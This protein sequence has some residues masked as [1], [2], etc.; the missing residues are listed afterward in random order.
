MALISFQNISFHYDSPY[1][2]IFDS[3]SFTLDASWKTG[4]VGRNGRGKTTLL[5]LLTGGLE[6][7]KGKITALPESVYFPFSVNNPEL[8]ALEAARNAVEDFS[9]WEEEMARLLSISDEK[10]LERYG[11]LEKRYNDAGGYTVR[12][13]LLAD[14][15]ALGLSPETAEKPFRVLS[16]GEKTKCLIAALFRKNN[17][18]PLLDEPTNHLDMEGREI[19]GE[20]LQKQKGFLVISHDRHFLDLCTDHILGLEKNSI[21]VTKGNFS[22]W[23]EN[24]DRKENFER[25]QSDQI[26]RELKHLEKAARERRMHS[27]KAESGKLKKAESEGG[28]D[29]GAIGAVS[30]R[31]MKRAKV[32]E[33]RID[34]GIG[35]KKELLR[36]AVKNRKLKMDTVSEGPDILLRGD[37]ISIGFDGRV[38][39]QN[40]NFQV[41]KGDRIAVIGPNGCGKTS[42]I[43]A[44][45]GEI[46]LLSGTLFRPAHIRVDRV[47]QYPRYTNGLLE[48]LVAAEEADKIRNILAAFGFSGDVLRKRAEDLSQGEQKKFEIALSLVKPANLYIW[49]EPL[50]AVDLAGRE[51]IERLI[52]ETQ[53]AI[54]F[55]EHDRRFIENIATDIVV[56]EA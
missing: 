22:V 44:V 10:S 13:K 6:P 56:L 50:N 20:Y 28:M 47:S 5:K 45:F 29:K 14:F 15:E 25:A 41:R 3:V 9:L 34:N 48:D 23:K 2:E 17:A 55:T 37:G 53:P 11:E 46:P 33:R 4:V 16:G 8:T 12:E 18:F 21:T 40:L 24:R 43:K 35:Q 54:L 1:Q 52:L 49:D 27:T 31:L 32:L 36:D 26:K 42:L 30:A 39:F 51:E 38:L 7:V 19:L